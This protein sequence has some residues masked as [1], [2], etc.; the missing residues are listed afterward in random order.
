MGE[1]SCG[2][3]TLAGADCDLHRGG[4]QFA[5]RQPHPLVNAA[6][7]WPGGIQRSAWRWRQADTVRQFLTPAVTRTTKPFHDLS[8]LYML[9]RRAID[10]LGT[11][12]L[13]RSCLAR[14][15]LV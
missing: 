4:G 14:D 2:R 8:E 7:E 15:V 3:D 6:R 12:G 11:R 13:A 5:T 1:E 10:G 9:I